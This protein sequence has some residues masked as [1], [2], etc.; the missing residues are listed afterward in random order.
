MLFR[1]THERDGPVLPRVEW[2]A[3]HLATRRPGALAGL[4][5][6][7]PLP[8]VPQR[9]LNFS[10][11][12]CTE[13]RGQDHTCRVQARQLALGRGARSMGQVGT[14]PL[15]PAGGAPSRMSPPA[16]CPPDS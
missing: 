14:E 4:G 9:P 1:N 2:Q 6:T 10:P 3:P 13:E 7:L 15:V 11:C 5:L 12:I 16:G 8:L